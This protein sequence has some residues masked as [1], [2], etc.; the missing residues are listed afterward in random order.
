MVFM[1]N[2]PQAPAE[3]QAIFLELIENGIRHIADR[4]LADRFE[5]VLHGDR[6]AL[7]VLDP[8]RRR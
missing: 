7:A 8:S 2:Q 1:V 6:A 4:M 5:E 3:G